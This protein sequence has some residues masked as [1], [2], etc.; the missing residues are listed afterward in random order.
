[1][2]KHVIFRNFIARDIA[3][4]RGARLAEQ[5]EAELVAARAELA[6][7]TARRVAA[8]ASVAEQMAVTKGRRPAD[9]IATIHEFLRCL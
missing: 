8:D 9:V 4:R 1:M 6:A 3:A 2:Q 7:A 5:A